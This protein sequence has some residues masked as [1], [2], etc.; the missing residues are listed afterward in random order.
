MGNGTLTAANRRLLAA[1]DGLLLAS[2]I[3]V[4]GGPELLKTER[5]CS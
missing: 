2:G 1:N 3:R 5:A 4:G